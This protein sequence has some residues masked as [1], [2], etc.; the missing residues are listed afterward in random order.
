MSFVGIVSIA[1][2]SAFFIILAIA[3]VASCLAELPYNGNQ[4]TTKRDEEVGHS[5]IVD[6]LREIRKFSHNPHQESHPLDDTILALEKRNEELRLENIKLERIGQLEKQHK[7]LIAEGKKISRLSTEFGNST[8][9]VAEECQQ[10]TTMLE[11][12]N[13][14]LQYINN[15]HEWFQDAGG[16]WCFGTREEQWYPDP[17]QPTYGTLLKEIMDKTK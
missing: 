12:F 11:D 8:D 1:F 15:T 14:H 2:I 9:E 10:I 17:N 16:K 4:A 6:G 3:F 7:E 5:F 13:R